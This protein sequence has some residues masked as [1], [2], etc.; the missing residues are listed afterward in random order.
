MPSHWIVCILGGI[1]EDLGLAVALA[2]PATEMRHQRNLIRTERNPLVI[3]RKLSRIT[4][5]LAKICRQCGDEEGELVAWGAKVDDL[6]GNM[7][8]VGGENLKGR[9]A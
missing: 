7:K 3:Q 6:L 4:K 1:L 5:S 9:G 2:G 8:V